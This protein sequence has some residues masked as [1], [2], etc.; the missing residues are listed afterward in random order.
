MDV[1]TTAINAIE[2]KSDLIIS[3]SD[4]IWDYAEL[5]LQEEKSAELYCS[6]LEAEG[7]A[8]LRGY[9]VSKRLFQPPSVKESRL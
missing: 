9:A 5:S 1:K 4:K 8:V 7:F 2:E 3:V 6:V